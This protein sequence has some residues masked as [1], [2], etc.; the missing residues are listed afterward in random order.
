MRLWARKRQKNTKNVLR[1]GS[2]ARLSW[3]V[4]SCSIGRSTWVD[5]RE[6]CGRPTRELRK[7]CARSLHDLAQ[8]CASSAYRPG[9][10]KIDPASNSRRPGAA[11]AAGSAPSKYLSR[12]F[13][14]KSLFLDP[15]GIIMGLW[16]MDY[17]IM[18][19]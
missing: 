6:I 1:L 4:D 14:I 9:Y 10:P 3:A 19:L 12:N 11:G 13:N 15:A 16:I 17:E 18:R 2:K 8:V 7:R 5:L